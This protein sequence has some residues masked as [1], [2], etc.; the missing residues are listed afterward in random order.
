MPSTSPE[1]VPALGEDMFGR[2][3]DTALDGMV[4]IDALVTVRLCN[5]ACERLFGY[6]AKK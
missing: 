1:S 2:V 5:A 6:P 3:L 4:V